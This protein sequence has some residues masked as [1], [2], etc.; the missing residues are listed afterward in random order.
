MWWRHEAL[1]AGCDFDVLLGCGDGAGGADAGPAAD[2]DPLAPDADP[3]APDGGPGGDAGTGPDLAVCHATCAAPADCSQGTAAY[4]ADNYDCDQGTCVW[5]GC[6]STAECTETF[7][8]QTYT[9]AVRGQFDLPSCYATC[10]APGDCALGA[11]TLHD[12]DNYDCEQ[13]A[14]VW[15]GC[16][17]TAE[18]VDALQDPDYVCR[19]GVCW[20]GCGTVADCTTGSSLYDA[21]NYACVDDTCRWT[22]CNSTAE[23]TDTFM[24]PD[25]TCR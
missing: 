19:Q 10:T 7:Q 14:C 13:G 25:Y 6:N 8:S 11:S 21:D 2:A 15:I 20:P 18:C 24:S 4:D 16:N 23:C 22:G 1:S 12:A 3:L 5:T 17:A 9:C